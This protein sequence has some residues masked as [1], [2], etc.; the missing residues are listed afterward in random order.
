MFKRV[1]RYKPLHTLINSDFMSKEES[2]TV[3][4][5]RIPNSVF[6]KVKEA[7]QA[8]GYLNESDFVRHAIREKLD[9]T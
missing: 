9:R 8:D 7:V 6:E 1:T 2:K 5:V 3:V 4:S